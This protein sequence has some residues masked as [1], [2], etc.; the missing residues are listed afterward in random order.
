MRRWWDDADR[1]AK[2]TE[3]VRE[4][5]ERD[6]GTDGLAAAIFRCRLIS[7]HV[8]AREIASAIATH[9]MERRRRSLPAGVVPYG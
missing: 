1:K 2:Y 8:P 6:V 7:L 5:V 3:A 4:F 9:G